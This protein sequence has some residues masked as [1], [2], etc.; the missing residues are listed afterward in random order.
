MEEIPQRVNS[1]P[2]EVGHHKEHQKEG[3]LCPLDTVE[4][5]LRDIPRMVLVLDRGLVHRMVVLL[6][7]VL[8]LDIL[9]VEVASQGILRRPGNLRCL[10]K[11]E[12]QVEV[13]VRAVGAVAP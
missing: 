13:E 4:K 2:L 6:E 8:V 3:E 12:V 9:P 7:T 5:L 1:S 10:G 11:V